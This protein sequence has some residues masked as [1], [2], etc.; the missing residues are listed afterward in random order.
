MVLSSRGQ[1]GNKAPM[2]NVAVEKQAGVPED[3]AEQGVIGIRV[4]ELGVWLDALGTGLRLAAPTGY[5]RFVQS[6]GSARPDDLQLA[7]RSETLPKGGPSGRRLAL[8]ETWE[9]WQDDTGRLVFVA[10]RQSPPR[11]VTVDP[12]FRSG[13]ILGDFRAELGAPQYPLQLIDIKLHAN[14]L[15]ER[16]DV[17]L[18]ASG[19]AI[20]G[21]GYCFAAFSG[22]GK[23]TIAAALASDPSVTVLGEDQVVLRYLD[24]R[25]WIYGTPWHL[26]PAMC[27][28]LGVPLEKLFLLDRSAPPG[29]AP[30]SPADG[31]TRLMQTAFVPYYRPAAVSAIMDRLALLA[32]QVPFRTLSYRLGTDPLPLV[33]YA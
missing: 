19:V 29:A 20:D 18:H 30:C 28:P 14:W 6:P 23:S 7:V 16:G 9:L 25:F 33:M 3:V 22:I 1:L 32:Q 4:A 2:A 17:M 8:T 31:V 15:A 27:A 24:G 26:N 12:G 11:W 13:E 10:P 5:A 21:R